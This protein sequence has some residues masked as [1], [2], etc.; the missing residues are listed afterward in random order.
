MGS[1]VAEQEVVLT[2][3]STIYIDVLL[4]IFRS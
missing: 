2:E 4:V 3:A 1:S